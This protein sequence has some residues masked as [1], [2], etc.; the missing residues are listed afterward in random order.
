TLAQCMPA[1]DSRIDVQQLVKTVTWIALELDFDD[2][3][4]P[5]FTDEAPARLLNLLLIYCLDKRARASEVDWI[6]P[7]TSRNQ[8]RH[9]LSFEAKRS[10]G[11]LFLATP[12]YQFLN[13]DDARIYHPAS[14]VIT[15]KE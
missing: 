15:D 8:R 3:R 14:F 11:E 13:Q 9:R 4:E 1:P 7:G 2:T 12:G 6:L 10:I 5:H